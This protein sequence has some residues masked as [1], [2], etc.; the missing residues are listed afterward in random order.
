MVEAVSPNADYK[1][2]KKE[3]V[4]YL[5]GAIISLSSIASYALKLILMTS[6]QPKTPVT[7]KS[8]GGESK[9]LFVGNLSFQVEQADVYVEF[10]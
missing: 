10:P 1:Q 2:G 6:M 9:T 7:P 3:A 8:Q 4:S 5:H